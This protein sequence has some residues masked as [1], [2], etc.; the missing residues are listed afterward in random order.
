MNKKHNLLKK[1]IKEAIWERKNKVA[2]I[3]YDWDKYKNYSLIKIEIVAVDKN[4]K[5]IIKPITK[6]KQAISIDLAQK[7][8]RGEIGQ[9]DL[10]RKRN[11]VAENEAKKETKLLQ[12]KGYKIAN[13]PQK[14]NLTHGTEEIKRIILSSYINHMRKQQGGTLSISSGGEE[15]Q[16]SLPAGK[17]GELSV[18]DKNKGSGTFD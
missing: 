4:G 10:N 12:G 11:A 2:Y 9:A 18:V 5:N 15:G 3:F 13:N 8:T 7:S 1:Y 16:L 17:G 14:I 6:I